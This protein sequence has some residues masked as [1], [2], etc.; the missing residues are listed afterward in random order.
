MQIDEQEYLAHYGILRR[1]GR[2]PWGSSGWGKNPPDDYTNNM[3]FVDHID[4]LKRQGLTDADIA[5][6]FSTEDHKISVNQLRA[7]KSLAKTQMKQAD[8]LMA[9]RLRAKGMS[10]TAIGE[11][12]GKPESTVRTLLAPGA[13]DKA[14]NLK[15]I[16]DML[17]SHVDEKSYVDVG[18]GTENHL[19]VSA[20]KLEIAL[21]AL[22]EEG[23]EVHTYPMRIMTGDR[24][25]QKKVLCK[26]GTTQKQAWE[27][28]FNTHIITEVSDDGGRSFYGVHPPI[29]VDPKRVAIR[30]GPDGG[31]K[32][33]G[34]I[35][36]R[37]NVPDLDMG[38]KNYGQVRIQVGPNHYLK[39]MALL[40]DDLPPGID[41]M[42]NTNKKDTGDKFDA[43]KPVEKDPI[44]GE[45]D[46]NNPFGAI[47][48]QIV[49][50]PN[51]PNER[52]TSAINIV[53][54]LTSDPESG[55][56]EGR[57]EEWG[58]NLSS[59]FL[60]KQS[61][62]LAKQQLDMTYENRQNNLEA[63]RALTN[64][65]VKKKLLN[66]FADDT[67]ES[68]VHLEAAALPRM[69]VHVLLPLT[70]IKP[71]QV[72]A[73]RFRPGE[74]VV[75]IRHPHG[76]TFEIPE[77]VVNNNNR[78]GK[79]LITGESPDAIGIHH[80][81]AQR[82]SGADFDG[83]TVLVIPNNNNAV[84]TAPIL[85]DLKN[86][87][88]QREYPG[89]EGMK[90]MGNKQAE[91]GSISNLITDMSLQEAPLEHIARAIKHSMVVIDAV[92]KKL[93]YK[94]SY[95]DNGIKDLQEKYQTGGA[96][97]LISRAGAKVYLPQRQERLHKHGGPV[98]PVTGEREYEPTGK[99]NRKGEPRRSVV[100]KLSIYP[101]HELMS[102]PTGLPMERLY[103]NH[104]E[105]LKKLA[106][107]A[108]LEA[109]NTPG[110]KQ[111][112]SARATYEKEYLSLKS[113]VAG[114]KRNQPLERQANLLA[115]RQFRMVMDQN[116]GMDRKTENKIKYQITEE[117][118][119]RTGAEKHRIDITPSEWD[120][121]QAGAI[122]DSMLNT[123]L[124]HA[125]MGKV[126]EY[127]MP[128]DKK[129]MTPTHVNRA[130]QM[131]KDG[132]TLSEV[133]DYL[134]VSVSTL[135]ASVK[136]SEIV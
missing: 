4:L 19:D 69:S 62:T 93:D 47:I 133:A 70:S 17:R 101:A 18:A 108:R 86:F 67:E 1:S 24:E 55:N 119:R 125:D 36:V 14:D 129:L 35:Y 52:V 30:Y 48:R 9:E 134:G 43:M 46:K 56:V 113:K 80:S 121:I 5:K 88:P 130:T 40:T 91:M 75:L 10:N 123:I 12:M 45:T 50:D 118:R 58:R 13:K 77:L 132:Y 15:S 99:L 98:N 127:A 83:D 33:D 128:K 65:T 72:Y 90:I 103:A 8:I 126:R 95:R 32:A 39:G 87:D 34:C 61:P 26:P 135:N 85:E 106:R 68:G 21:Y 136:V 122:S 78:E 117:M 120:A 31:S 92:N 107:E 71:N 7:E 73:P 110:T 111:N 96:S 29:Q 42:F 63:I 131:L 25:I 28:R 59:Q 37:R 97:T 76:G 11:R 60:S 104:S 115:N 109:L 6:G 22:R 66:Q 124:T 49:A 100:R 74:R 53:G 51:T 41:L 16:K 64:N 57:W 27:N 114:V 112:A 2:Y 82:M 84:T 81:V 102:S 54:G 38:G 105:K 116:P 23:Y 20:N 79:R 44:T 89:Y 94:G 3:A